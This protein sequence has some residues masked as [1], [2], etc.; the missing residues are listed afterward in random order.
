MD[1]R[2]G[3][4]SAG[5]GAAVMAA[6]ASLAHAQQPPRCEPNERGSAFE[7]KRCADLGAVVDSAKQA[8]DPSQG[9]VSELLGV[10]KGVEGVTVRLTLETRELSQ[11]S[12]YGGLQ[13][14]PLDAGWAEASRVAVQQCTQREMP[15][16]HFNG[17]MSHDIYILCS[18]GGVTWRDATDA[19]I[20]MTPWYFEKVDSVNW[21]QANRAAEHLCAKAKRGFAGGHFNGHQVGSKYGLFCYGEG[22]K[23]FDATGAELAATGFGFATPR[24]DD[25]KWDQA[26]RAATNFCVG[27]GFD[28]GFMNGHQ[29]PDRY[30]IVC[31]R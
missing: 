25:V 14:I 9:P 16:G 4:F 19:E 8:N 18:T 23:W 2:S 1:I 10:S 28:G 11:P 6:W 12:P 15:A 7:R 31:Q 27:K 22:A 13:N 30:G 3:L 24:L 26:M 29:A 21:A 17:H 5:L 20:A